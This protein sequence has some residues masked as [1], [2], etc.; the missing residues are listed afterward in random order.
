[1]KKRIENKTV[2]KATNGGRYGAIGSIMQ[3]R[4]GFDYLRICDVVNMKKFMIPHDV[5][6]DQMDK[7]QRPDGS[8]KEQNKG[9]YKFQ[10]SMKY[11]NYTPINRG[12]KETKENTDLLLKYEQKLDPKLYNEE[13]RKKYFIKNADVYMKDPAIVGKLMERMVAEI[14]G[15]VFED[16]AHYD[17]YAK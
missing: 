1:M 8:W 2:S 10:F 9:G 3:K 4:N 6:F 14:E 16:G 17:S 5:F 7:W 11:E 12:T 15:E 13:A